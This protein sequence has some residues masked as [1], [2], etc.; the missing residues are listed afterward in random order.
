MGK[1]SEAQTLAQMRLH[2]AQLDEV[3]LEA[4]LAFAEHLHDSSESYVDRWLFGPASELQ[5]CRAARRGPAR[6]LS[7]HSVSPSPPKS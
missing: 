2:D 6:S 1:L 4:A 5:H 3:D 7:A